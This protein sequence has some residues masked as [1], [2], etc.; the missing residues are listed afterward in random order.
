MN[1]VSNEQVSNVVV[2]MNWSQLSAH[3]TKHASLQNIIYPG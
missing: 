1:V 2:T 3:Q